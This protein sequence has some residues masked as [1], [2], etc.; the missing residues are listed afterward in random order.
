MRFEITAEFLAEQG[1]S[2]T[3]TSRFWAKVQRSDACWLWTGC[4]NR[5]GYGRIAC[6]GVTFNSILANRASWILHFGPI[7]EGKCVLHS[8]DNP[9]CVNPNHL[10]LGTHDDNMKDMV[11]KERATCA[12]HHGEANGQAKLTT[13]QVQEIRL[14]YAAGDLTQRELG[15]QFHVARRTV[16]A[17]TSGTN[18][19]H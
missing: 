3:F 16:G 10:F 5:L 7:P 11:L 9:P 17:I 1:F 8:C 13:G 19:K 14:L 6:G 18:W 12:D 2:P 15:K 4:R